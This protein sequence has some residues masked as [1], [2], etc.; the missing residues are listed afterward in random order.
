ML[1]CDIS[2]DVSLLSVST[3]AIVSVTSM[4]IASV[5]SAREGYIVFTSFDS[6]CTSF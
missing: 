2:R 1:A 4:E 6:S 5:G 3:A